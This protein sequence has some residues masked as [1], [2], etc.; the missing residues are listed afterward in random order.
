MGAGRVFEHM[1]PAL[2][3]DRIMEPAETEGWLARLSPAVEDHLMT[4]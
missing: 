4:D 2:D 1:A 3:L